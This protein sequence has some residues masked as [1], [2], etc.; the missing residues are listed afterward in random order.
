MCPTWSGW[1]SLR[2]RSAAASSPPMSEKASLKILVVDDEPEVRDMV[3]NVLQAILPT[4]GE[5][6][7]FAMKAAF[8]QLIATAVKR[9]QPR[10]TTPER[11]GGAAVVV[12]PSAYGTGTDDHGEVPRIM[13]GSVFGRR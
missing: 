7:L 4:I 1:P 6:K 8:A 11:W 12:H 5:W 9:P 2:E 3:A 10:L 13:K